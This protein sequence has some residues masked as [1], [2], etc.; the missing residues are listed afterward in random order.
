VDRF[1][2]SWKRPGLRRGD[3][4]KM[5]VPVFLR[6]PKA[7]KHRTSHNWKIDMLRVLEDK[8]WQND[9]KTGIARIHC[10]GIN[11]AKVFECKYKQ[12]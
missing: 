1:S 6:E 10:M 11:E 2:F 5:V 3:A 9:Q 12:I 7:C 8:A 4:E